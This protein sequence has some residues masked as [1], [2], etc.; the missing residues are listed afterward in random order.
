[1]TMTELR[2]RLVAWG[3]F[4]LAVSAGIHAEGL[5]EDAQP[6]AMPATQV[7]EASKL[8]AVDEDYSAVFLL[9]TTRI[10]FDERLRARQTLHQ[11]YR[12]DTANAIVE[13][14]EINASWEPERQERPI[15]RARVIAPDGSESR[16]D[17]GTLSEESPPRV[18]PLQFDDTRTLRGPLP[19]LAVG[20]V[21][22]VETVIVDREP[23]FEGGTSDRLHV[24]VNGK[25]ERTVISVSAPASVPLHYAARGLPDASI[26]D[27]A[28]AGRRVVTLRQ[29]P[30]AIQFKDVYWEAMGDH[31]IWPEFIYST[32]ADWQAVSAAYERRT[33]ALIRP[34]EVRSLAPANL[35]TE[36]HT[37]VTALLKRLR[38]KV[39]YTAVLFGEGRII[40]NPPAVTLARGFGDC[41]DMAV[42]LVSMLR[43]AGVPAQLA[44]LNSGTTSDLDPGLPGLGLFNHVIVHVP[45]ES[46]IWI[47]P[48]VK[49]MRS[50]ELPIENSGRWALL[51]APADASLVRTPDALSS[52]HVTIENVEIRI[53]DFGK[54]ALSVRGSQGGVG[55]ATFREF[56]TDASAADRKRLE[57]VF[58]MQYSAKTAAGF[59]I[60][61]D[62]ET[63]MV[64]YDIDLVELGN[65][66]TDFNTAVVKLSLHSHFS[67][68]PLGLRS[69]EAANNF[70]EVSD[71]A[72]EKE[73]R[74][75]RTIDWVF[76]PFKSEW[77][78]KVVA[79]TGFRLKAVPADREM[80]LGPASYRLDYEQDT[81]GNLVATIELDTKNGRY[82]ADQGRAFREA[83]KSLEP[84]LLLE[85]H[86]DHEAAILMAAGDESG[87]LRRDAELAAANPTRA[88]H[89]TRAAQRLL[90][91]G[92]VKE[93]LVE[94][95]K[96]TKMEPDRSV[97]FVAL[98]SI[99]EHD[100]LGRRFGPGFE[101][102][103]ALSAH[104]ESVRLDPE[105][106]EL[107]SNVA[108]V[109]AFNSDGIR[110]GPGA[111]L[112][113]AVAN[114]RLLAKKRP[115][116]ADWN[117]QLLECLWRQRKYEEVASVVADLDEG[118]AVGR[119]RMAS[120]VMTAG[121]TTALRE[122]TGRGDAATVRKRTKDAINSLWVNGFYAEAKELTAASGIDMLHGED[123]MWMSLLT[124]MQHEEALAMPPPTA[125]GAAERIMRLVM[126]RDADKVALARWMSAR[127]RFVDDGRW[128]VDSVA[129]IGGMMNKSITRAFGDNRPFVRDILVSNLDFQE[130]ATTTE[131]REVAVM[132]NGF[133]VVVL[134][135]VPEKGD[136]RLLTM[137]PY[138]LPLS[139]EATARIDA[140]DLA[141][142]A[143]WIDIA[144]DEMEQ[145]DASS[146]VSGPGYLE[147]AWP[148]GSA[149][150]DPAVLR[151]A[152]AVLGT[153][154]PMTGLEVAALRKAS[155]LATAED[156]RW[157]WETVITDV[158]RQ[159]GDIPEF[160]N[161]AERAYAL[162]SSDGDSFSRLVKAYGAAE[163]WQDAERV[164]R[165]RLA[166]R[167]NDPRANHLLAEA[168]TGQG[169]AREGLEI[170]A[171][172]VRGTR[173][174][175]GILNNYAW[176]ALVAD[177]VDDAAIKA[178]ENSYNA[179]SGR[180]F[181]SAHTLASVYAANGQILESR[182]ILLK[183]LEDFQ[184]VGTLSDHI[185]LVRGLIAEN[186]GATDT[187]ID[188]YGE[189][190]KP[191]IGAPNSSY[192]VA[193]ARRAALMKGNSRSLSRGQ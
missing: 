17:P 156:H 139:R 60:T 101:R 175:P 67:E 42:A 125:A 114:F 28:V 87:A 26:S 91:V 86:Y 180:D 35:P 48:T 11:I 189:L 56:L 58:R 16:F 6:F 191:K 4:G 142:A 46:P 117:A 166:K 97:A 9:E 130:T 75:P 14:G 158:A 57:D 164:C 154:Q 190:E 30:V 40:P 85:L 74:E 55:A 96:A 106:Y 127:S 143:N 34:D 133:P 38:D 182:R 54:G 146:D 176:Q 69:D 150:T 126:T 168:L 65:A 81:D 155:A 138:W 25:V 184:T 187:A 167:P 19:A 89:R 77:H 63:G 79:P 174:T 71:A 1:M 68:I 110:F 73:V 88:I 43:A 179:R 160:V 121:V 132:M 153:G 129:A 51:V 193:V 170:L 149:A 192:L 64:S 15:M 76:A 148:R 171:Q 22:E 118:E 37:L 2:V 99:L 177:A 141:G 49:Y 140:G 151:L 72:A 123:A 10:E 27:E 111:D 83:Y 185:W 18:N 70:F 84:S 80:A 29:G 122:E 44:L 36:R 157:L 115:G 159:A 173:A 98:G 52:A 137:A 78:V 61:S 135:L 163:R 23:A 33:A 92:L 152:A 5:P 32:G 8:V 59:N 66:V 95:R 3:C 134:Y 21:I 169:R 162:D 145:M 90:D 47:D 105:N 104:R 144:R 124:R 181:S 39:R 24:G 45:G 50:G 82:T 7:L 113:Q 107:Y 53:A 31:P 183:L 41:K 178:A 20:S 116:L 12:L 128:L 102:D 131:V 161:A 147:R 62:D 186:L 120:R 172:G 94:A 108:G 93:A 109:A 136:W 165:E 119:F 13:L 100:E 103:A 112:D 188:A